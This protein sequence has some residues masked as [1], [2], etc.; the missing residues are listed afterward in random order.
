MMAGGYVM[1]WDSPSVGTPTFSLSI[2]LMKKGKERDFNV[3]FKTLSRVMSQFQGK[4]IH[5]ASIKTGKS[6]KCIA[7]L[8]G[9]S[10]GP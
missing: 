5:D 1:A 9:G 3:L 2:V 4:R 7:Y 8:S 6:N 10:D